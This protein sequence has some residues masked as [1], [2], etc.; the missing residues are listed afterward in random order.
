[1][2]KA[3]LH[4]HTTVSDG[5]YSP[6][7]LV[8]LALQRSI[9]TL[10]ITD[11]D[12][13]D[14][15]FEALQHAR[16]KGG[17]NIIVGAEISTNYHGKET[18]MLAYLF[19]PQ[20]SELV[21]LLSRQKGA[22]IRRASQIIE[23]LNA[24][25]LDISLEEVTEYAGNGLIGRPHFAKILQKK[26]LVSSHNE[27]FIK[28][29]GDGGSAFSTLDNCDIQDAIKT[30]HSA[31]GVAILAHPGKYT[32]DEKLEELREMGIDGVEYIHPSHDFSL[33]KKYQQWARSHN[34]ICT[35]GSDFH[36]FT[37]R[38]NQYF[39][40]V[41]VDATIVANLRQKAQPLNRVQ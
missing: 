8:D 36:G 37:N 24:E 39:G 11:H 27:A 28:Y 23:K 32:T 1:M 15:Y 2:V 7:Q 29:L 38:D 14:G 16:Q 3:D 13:C 10:A 34:L 22:R 18:H 20:N 35:G 5:K 25:G 6:T 30:V 9:T 4:T 12:S 41:C 19:D 21:G 31:G 40:L 33:Q 26:G 17:I